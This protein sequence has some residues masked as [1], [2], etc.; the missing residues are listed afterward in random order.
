MSVRTSAR[1]FPSTT[2]DT[3]EPLSAIPEMRLSFAFAETV[4]PVATSEIVGL[5]GAIVSTST[6]TE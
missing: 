5:G 6:R 2:K 1:K 3:L 4:P